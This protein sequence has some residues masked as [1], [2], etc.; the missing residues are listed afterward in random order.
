[1]I[2]YWKRTWQVAVGAI[3]DV[4]SDPITILPCVVPD[5]LTAPL[6]CWVI[7]LED[8]EPQAPPVVVEK[9]KV[10]LNEPVL[11]AEKS[12]SMLTDIE[13]VTILPTL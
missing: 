9:G 13:Q 4:S 7:L 1:L 6:N 3:S 11:F 10:K 2:S 8:K 12:T 5:A